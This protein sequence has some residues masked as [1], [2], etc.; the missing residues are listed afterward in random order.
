MIYGVTGMPLA[1][2]TTVARYLVDIGYSK[3]DMGDVVREEMKERKIPV[4]KTGQWVNKQ[5]EKNGMN[6]IAQ[7]TAPRIRE[8]EENNIVITGMRSLEEKRYFEN[9]LEQNVEMIA[10]WSSQKTRKH[11]RQK[12][13]REEDK[14]GQDFKERDQRE[15][16]N[17]VGD[18]MALS[19]H[20]IVNEDLDE[21]ELK[22]KVN[23]IAK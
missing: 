22:E 3:V 7:L 5:R 12:R 17:G 1:G 16:E 10:L 13:M 20:L 11:R 9:E 8:I 14:K 21:D 2:K 15:L 6:A 23:Q 18:L 4:E 19:K